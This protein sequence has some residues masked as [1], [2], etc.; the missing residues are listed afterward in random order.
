MTLTHVESRPSTTTDGQIEFLVQCETTGSS[1][2]NVLTSL[3]KVVDNVRIEKE[4]ITKRGEIM[5]MN[6]YTMREGW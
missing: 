1:S 4:E 5:C 3:Q 6:D 2:K